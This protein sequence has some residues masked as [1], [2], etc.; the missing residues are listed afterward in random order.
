MNKMKILICGNR[1]FTDIDK[2][3]EVIS[4]LPKKDTVI[5]HGAAKGADSIAGQVAAEVGLRVLAFPADWKKYGRA[6]GPIRNKKMLIEG[7]PN[8]VYAFYR[9][10]AESKGTKN[11]VNQAIKAGIKVIVYESKES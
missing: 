2:I 7:K 8:I 6:A 10:K 11:M 3:R 9:D 5:I 4:S 1:S